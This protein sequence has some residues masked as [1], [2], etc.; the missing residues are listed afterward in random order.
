MICVGQASKSHTQL[1]SYSWESTITMEASLD[2]VL[3]VSRVMWGLDGDAK[4]GRRGS[5]QH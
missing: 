3:G 1:T 2:R 4:G 5:E